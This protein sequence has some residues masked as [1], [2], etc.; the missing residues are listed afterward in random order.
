MTVILV[1]WCTAAF[2]WP[3]FWTVD[4]VIALRRATRTLRLA[5]EESRRLGRL[6]EIKR[7]KAVARTRRV[8]TGRSGSLDDEGD[9]V[10]RD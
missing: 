9:E 6:I 5:E 4:R 8:R 3:I 2:G 7:L 1:I 10:G